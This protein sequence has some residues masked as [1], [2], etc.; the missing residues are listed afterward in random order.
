MT[1]QAESEPRSGI[2]TLYRRYR[3]QAR[4]TANRFYPFDAAEA[5]DVVQDVFVSLCETIDRIDVSRPMAGWIGRVTNNRCHDRRRRAMVTQQ[6][7]R[8]N[9]STGV[10]SELEARIEGRDA[11]SHILSALERLPAQQA[12]AFHEH[13]LQGVEQ[14]VIAEQLGVTNGYVSKL[15]KMARSTLLQ[16]IH[17]STPRLA[18]EG[19]CG[20][21]ETTTDQ[22]RRQSMNKK[23]NGSSDKAGIGG[24]L[25]GF[26]NVVDLLSNLAEK[27]DALGQ[28]VRREGEAGDG[29]GVKAVYGF[30]LRVGGANGEPVV[31]H[32]GNVKDDEEHGATVE[33]QREPMVDVFDESDHVQLVAELPGVD[34]PDIRFELRH[35]VLELSAQRGDRRYH[36][37]IL[38]PAAVSLKGS[39]SS[40]NNG[41][42]ELTLPKIDESGSNG[43][44]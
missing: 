6:T 38:L 33:Q 30:S 13:Y 19:T 10:A 37:E 25:R 39:R 5:E 17:E 32:F 4:R 11:L 27:A 23:T 15:L 35:D 29:R 41:I 14:K 3:A 20:S 42:F 1:M 2:D 24:I 22:K 18:T 31:Q 7:I 40:Y 16:E 28:E 34:G 12:H 26:G 8:A 43:S 36:K 44:E 9:T 21:R